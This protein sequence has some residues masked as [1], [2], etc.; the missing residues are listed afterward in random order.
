MQRFEELGTQIST[1]KTI[2][3]TWQ[4]TI[5]ND[6]VNKKDNKKQACPKK[7]KQKDPHHYADLSQD[8]T[9]LK[10]RK[11]TQQTLNW[12][13]PSINAQQQP[14]PRNQRRHTLN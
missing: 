11:P 5:G 14:P 13:Q 10:T 3:D 8:D 2:S 4:R 12:N 1:S 6:R 7:T 9:R